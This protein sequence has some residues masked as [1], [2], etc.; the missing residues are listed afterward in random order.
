MYRALIRSFD[1]DSEDEDVECLNEIIMIFGLNKAV[2]SIKYK[3]RRLNWDEHVQK[4]QH[5]KQFHSRY[6]MT[7]PSFN[8]LVELLRPSIVVNETKSRNSTGNNEPIY[9]EM[10]VGAG[11]RFLGGS[12]YKDIEDIYGISNH[13]ARRI[14]ILFVSAVRLCGEMDI[15]LP[16]TA[17][18]LE[19]TA[20]G[21]EA[22][23]SASGVYYGCVGCIDG[24]LLCINKP[25]ESTGVRPSDYFSGHYSRFGLNVQAMCDSQLRFT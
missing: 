4:L 8:K 5:T 19:E 24:W 14:I 16:R 22:C 18:E 13:S 3:H 1:D 21:F 9:P 20:K 25:R 15:R 2:K 11:L 10:I 17:R 23:S 7:L 6:H 12:F